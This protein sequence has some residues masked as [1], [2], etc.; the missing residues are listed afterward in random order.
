[1]AIYVVVERTEELNRQLPSAVV[2]VRPAA[3]GFNPETV[4]TNAFQRENNELGRREIARRARAEFDLMAR[5]LRDAGVN[6]IIVEDREEPSTPDAIFPNNWISFH[7]DGTAVLYPMFSPLRRLERRRDIIDQVAAQG[8]KVKRVVDLSHHEKEGRFLEGTG[9]I[10]FDHLHRTAYANLSPRTNPQVLKELCDLLDYKAVTFRAT[11]EN[12]QDIYHTNVL[13]SIGDRFAIV[14]AD[15]IP[16][17][18][19]RKL[20][21]DSLRMTRREI[22]TIDRQQLAHFA[23]NVL[24]VPAQNGTTVLA[25]STQALLAFRPDQ[26]SAIQQYA[27]IVEAPLPL[28]EGIEGGSARCMMAGV[29][30]PLARD[31]HQ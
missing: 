12:G 4:S 30:L 25:M 13:M 24:Q 6:L 18:I 21:L 22:V 7:D 29:H 1:M 16:D 19:E 8:F 3:F 9:S 15:A 2:M 5:R 20:V 31:L 10:V 11:D 28:I 17:A 27:H 23:G 26:R 14:C